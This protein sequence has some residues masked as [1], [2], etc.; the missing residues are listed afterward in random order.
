MDT[1]RCGR[2]REWLPISAFALRSASKDGLQNTCRECSSAWAKAHRPR[3]F[4]AAPSV[5]LGEKWCRRC[6]LVQP[7]DAFAV[8]RTAADGR[9]AQCRTCAAAA[10][11]E[12]REQSGHIVRPA[13]I[14]PGHKFCR[15]CQR[16]LPHSEWAVRSTTKDGLAFR[17]KTCM[18]A[19]D[20][21]KHLQRTYGMSVADLD[22]MLDAQ[23]GVC[24]I[25]QT[26]PAVHVD[27]DHRSGRV[28]GLLCFRCN[29]AIGQLGDDPLVVRRAA[30]YL[31]RGGF[32]AVPDR[33]LDVATE[34]QR[35]APSVM[36][37]VLRARL[38]DADS[39]SAS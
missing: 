3:K 7:S 33:S 26:G 1:K 6:E 19:S 35:E 14:P 12:K 21:A 15:G 32:R 28:R 31:E 29:A 34:P 18:S 38:A 5:E 27:H 8:N 10:Y 11:R 24:A 37:R 2:C 9:Q 23:H 20:Q 36:E 30:R 4:K 17:C 16:V 39:G 25:C 13:D 22:A